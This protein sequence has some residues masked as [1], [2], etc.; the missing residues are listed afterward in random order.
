MS[1]SRPR[2]LA[3]RGTPQ[4]VYPYV[5]RVVATVSTI[6]RPASTP[7]DT[8]K[9]AAHAEGFRWRPTSPWL[10]WG[11][12]FAELR[13]RWGCWRRRQPLIWSKSCPPR[14]K[15]TASSGRSRPPHGQNQ[16]P[17]L[18]KAVP[19]TAKSDPRIWSK[20]PPY[21]SDR[22]PIPQS[23]PPHGSD[24]WRIYLTPRNSSRAP[25]PTSAPS[26]PGLFFH[27]PRNVLGRPVE[28]EGMTAQSSAVEPRT[29]S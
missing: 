17:H 10:G 25:A 16:P 8:W 19:L 29:S 24:G 3:L 14:P 13:L 27:D 18:V 7:S 12:C 2:Q 22:C 9:R 4:A 20:R 21:G 15:P 11:E 6:S 1:R 26:R 23:R 5:L 28:R